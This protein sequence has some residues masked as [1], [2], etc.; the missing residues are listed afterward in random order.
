MTFT[1]DMMDED[2]RQLINEALQA[3]TEPTQTACTDPWHNLT[4][5][6]IDFYQEVNLYFFVIQ[7]GFSVCNH[8]HT[9]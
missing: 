3:I 7:V 6:F 9:Q 2:D 4:E 8:S 1:I 5:I